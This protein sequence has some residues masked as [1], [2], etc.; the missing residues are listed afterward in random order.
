MYDYLPLICIKHFE[1]TFCTRFQWQ[2]HTPGCVAVRMSDD[3]CRT[4][5]ANVPADVIKLYSYACVYRVAVIAVCL[6][7]HSLFHSQSISPLKHSSL[8]FTWHNGKATLYQWS[9]VKLQFFS[10]REPDRICPWHTWPLPRAHPSGVHLVSGR[11]CAP[12]G[13]ALRP[14]QMPPPPCLCSSGHGRT[15]C[16]QSSASLAS[17]WWSSGR[18]HAG[19]ASLPWCSTLVV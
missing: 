11:C 8:P 13:C 14:A 9:L 17:W 16:L 7:Y 2:R 12:V 5:Y 18:P 6:S 3:C 4:C 19:A 15:S 1:C 10:P